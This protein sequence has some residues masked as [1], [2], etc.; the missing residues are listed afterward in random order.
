MEY[1][2]TAAY[3]VGIGVTFH[4]IASTAVRMKAL[5]P[6][7]SGRDLAKLAGLAVFWPVTFIAGYLHFIFSGDV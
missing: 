2:I 1:A 7:I 5:G 3:L 4:L 6:T